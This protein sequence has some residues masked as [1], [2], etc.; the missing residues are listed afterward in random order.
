MCRKITSFA[1]DFTFLIRPVEKPLS[2]VRC[3]SN[4]S[5]RD[6]GCIDKARE[7]FGTANNLKLAYEPACFCGKA[8]RAVGIHVTLEPYAEEIGDVVNTIRI[9]E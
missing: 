4:S 1:P 3:F 2:P 6:C 8:M 7:G 9:A 5:T